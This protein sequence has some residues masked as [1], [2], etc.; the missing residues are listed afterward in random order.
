MPAES[1]LASIGTFYVR[2]S[3]VTCG[4]Y[5]IFLL[6]HYVFRTYQTVPLVSV[7]YVAIFIVMIIAAVF[8][9]QYQLHR[10]L[11][12]LKA[13]K[14]VEYSYHVESAFES[15]MKQPS[16]KGFAELAARQRFMKELHRLSTRGLTTADLMQF[17]LIV[18]ILLGVTLVYGYLVTN[19]IWLL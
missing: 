17:L 12:R 6:Q 10:L 19:D 5:C 9:T 16:E 3:W 1:S 2:F 15:V 18:A 11:T 14:L 8:V 7:G 13:R 4:A